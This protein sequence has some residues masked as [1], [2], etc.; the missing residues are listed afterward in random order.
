MANAPSGSASAAKLQRRTHVSGCASN[1]GGLANVHGCVTCVPEELARGEKMMRWDE[2]SGVFCVPVHMKLDPCGFYIHWQDAESGDVLDL[3]CVR[4]ARTG[5]YCRQPR[6]ARLREM[7]HFE[8]KEA[9][10]DVPLEDKCFSLVFGFDFANVNYMNFC[11][12]SKQTAQ[13]SV[14]FFYRDL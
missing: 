6:D 7:L 11:C 2:E 8:G 12:S 1:A 3:N 5:K 14:H 9:G 4:D 10:K 13:V